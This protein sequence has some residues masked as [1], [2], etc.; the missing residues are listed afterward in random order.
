MVKTITNCNVIFKRTIEMSV[1]LCKHFGKHGLAF[2]TPSDLS[3][4]SIQTLMKKA[5][6]GYRADRILRLAKAFHSG[7]LSERFF[8]DPAIPTAE[9]HRKILSLHGFGVF[10]TSNVLQLLGR[11]D[12]EV[13][14]WDTETVRLM[15][16]LRVRATT[17][18]GFRAAARGRYE[19]YRPYQFLAYWFELWLN[20][21]K[22][23][24]S[25]STRWTAGT[26][27]VAL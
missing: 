10:A 22:R 9:V 15:K 3:G 24:G 26:F 21:E 1:L 23:A 8:D 7:E 20:Y 25:L 13:E 4:V 11:Y 2:P 18:E 12:T 17:T 19:P 16:E 27:Q 14:A 6:V 5:N